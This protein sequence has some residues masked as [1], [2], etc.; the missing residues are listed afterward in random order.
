MQR[1]FAFN[2]LVL[3]A[4]LVATA[5]GAGD[6]K[7][8]DS[9]VTAIAAFDRLK[10]LV[11]DW[12]NSSSACDPG[13]EEVP[14]SDVVKYK[15]TGAGSALVEVSMPGTPMEMTSIYHLDG[16]DL[17]MTHYCALG[18]QPRLKL[19]KT[20][21]KADRLVFVSTAARTSIRLKTPTS[22]DWS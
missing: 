12:K 8:A 19:D 11:G 5:L 7:K 6:E 4:S 15:L 2:L 13:A 10:T 18:N 21:S 3:S 22:A 9:P 20:A 16:D 17:R 14:G 1:L